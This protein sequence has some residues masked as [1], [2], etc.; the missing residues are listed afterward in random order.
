MGC[1]ETLEYVNRPVSAGVE[2]SSG[3]H[4]VLVE[5]RS[6]SQVARDYGVPKAGYPSDQ[7]LSPR[8]GN[9]FR[10]PITTPD[11]QPDP[12]AASHCRPD[13]RAARYLGGQRARR[14]PAHHRLT[15]G[16]PLQTACLG[17][18]DQSA[19]TCRR[20]TQQRWLDD[21]SRCGLSVTAHRRITGPIVL[22]EFHKAI[23]IHGIPYPTLTD[24]GMVFT[25]C[26][27]A[28]KGGRNAVEAALRRPGVRC[29]VVVALASA[30]KSR[31]GDYRALKW[32]ATVGRLMPLA[33]RAGRRSV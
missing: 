12:T 6:Q 32:L 23:D 19:S 10:T 18:P 17:G 3:H 25:T 8:R 15:P 4:R 16:A 21:H 13:H 29:Q 30:F 9:R 27:D 14:P 24:N 33:C 2:S 26:F 20:T 11:Y 31:N 5:G 22:A 1:L 28:G 7:A